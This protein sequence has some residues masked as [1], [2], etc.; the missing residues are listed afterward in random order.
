MPGCLLVD[1]LAKTWSPVGVSRPPLDPSPYPR[2]SVVTAVRNGAATIRACLRSVAEQDVPGVEHVVVDGSSTDGTA[3]IVRSS[4]GVTWVSEPDAG[5]Y[6]AMNKGVRMASG[7]FILFL[8]ADDVLLADLRAVASRLTDPKTIYYGDA[9]WPG[10]HR[11]YDGRFG[12]M[13]LAL[14]NICHQSMFYPRAV[15]AKYAF[16]LRYRLQADWELNMRCFSDPDLRLEYLP[17]LVARYN[18]VD[19][20]STRHRDAAL[21]ADYPG[22]LWR[23]FPPHVALPVSALAIAGRVARKIGLRTGAA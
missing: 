1:R 10:R 11:L 23:H 13:K 6:D 22:L 9:Y 2:I 3:D 14:R 4:P 12:A 19:G 7:D 17:L 15:F 16:D 5:T 8:G 18:D 21:E 20:S